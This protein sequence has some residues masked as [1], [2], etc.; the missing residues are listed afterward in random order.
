MLSGFGTL[1]L[2][3]QTVLIR[4]DFVYNIL[5]GGAAGDGIETMSM[6]LE[7]LLKQ[8]GFFV[9]TTCDF[10]SRIRGGHNFV[11]IRFGLTPVESHCETLDGIFAMDNETFLL[12]RNKLYAEGFVLC[13]SSLARAVERPLPLQSS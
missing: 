3:Y 11:R 10:M 4:G 2:F 1:I 7:K 9:F 13:D 6:L 12:H 5:L 8:S